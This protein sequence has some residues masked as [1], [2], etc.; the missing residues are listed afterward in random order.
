V[1]FR[2]VGTQGLGQIF[3]QSLDQGRQGSV[4]ATCPANLFEDDS[5]QLFQDAELNGV[6]KRILAFKA[7]VNR[8]NNELRPIYD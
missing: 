1:H 4:L 5:V 7:I 2:A 8:A 6:E 3:Y